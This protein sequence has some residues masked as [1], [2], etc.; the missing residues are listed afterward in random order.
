MI[1]KIRLNRVLILGWRLLLMS[2]SRHLAVSL[3]LIQCLI[4]WTRNASSSPIRSRRPSIH[5]C[6]S[7]RRICLNSSVRWQMLT[8]WSWQCYRFCRDCKI[9]TELRLLWCL[10]LSLWVCPWS[11]TRLRT[12]SA[13]NRIMRRTILSQ[14]VHLEAAPPL[15]R[16]RASTSRSAVW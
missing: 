8:F 6:L 1:S 13:E 16:P 14:C 2:K 11:K 9:S 5:A 15:M 12:T 10:W 7:Y 3:K 4:K